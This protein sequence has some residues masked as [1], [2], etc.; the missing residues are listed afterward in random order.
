[1]INYRTSYLKIVHKSAEGVISFLLK[2]QLI[3]G[4]P[5]IMLTS[6]YALTFIVL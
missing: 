6:I 3:A 4:K 1:M 2:E 5:I